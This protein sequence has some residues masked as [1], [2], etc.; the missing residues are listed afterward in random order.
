MHFTAFEHPQPLQT[1]SAL[2]SSVLALCITRLLS[3]HNPYKCT[4]LYQVLSLHGAFEGF[5]APT[6]LT[7]TLSSTKFCSCIVHFKAFEHPQPLSYKHNQL[8]QVLFLHCAFQGFW[9][10]TALTNAICSTKFCPFCRWQNVPKT[11]RLKGRGELTAD[12]S[13]QSPCKHNQL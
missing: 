8:Y 4:L 7:N 11:E 10:P 2:P 13:T 5:W 6:A 1:Q 12:F 3:T 9:A